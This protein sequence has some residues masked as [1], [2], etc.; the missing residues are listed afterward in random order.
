[1]NYGIRPS[2]N[3]SFCSAN[4]CFVVACI[5][6]VVPDL[7]T[8]ISLIVVK[9]TNRFNWYIVALVSNGFLIAVRI[10]AVISFCS[11]RFDLSYSE[12][13]HLGP[14]LG[15]ST[16]VISALGLFIALCILPVVFEVIIWQ[17]YKETRASTYDPEALNSTFQENKRDFTAFSSAILPNA[18]KIVFAELEVQLT[19]F[20]ETNNT[21]GEILE[22]KK[23]LPVEYYGEDVDDDGNN[24]DY[25]TTPFHPQ[26][27]PLFTAASPS[28]LPM[29]H[30]V[31]HDPPVR[32]GRNVAFVFGIVFGLFVAVVVPI[33]WMNYGIKPSENVSFCSATICF[34]VACIPFVVPD[35][36]TSISLIVVKLTNRF[37]WYIVALVSNGFLIAVR[38]FAVIS[39]CSIRFDQSYSKVQHLGPFLGWSALVISALGLF[40]AL[41]I[42]PVV[43]E[44]II[45]QACKET[46]ASTYDPE[47]RNSMRMQDCKS[48]CSLE[49]SN[50]MNAM[51]VLAL[52]KITHSEKSTQCDFLSNVEN[53]RLISSMAFYPY[54]LKPNRQN[55][56]VQCSPMVDNA[57]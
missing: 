32:P 17:A 53:Q 9:L 3:V 7:I 22:L 48:E 13:Q 5:P 15:W 16:L 51:D 54:R 34:A 40:I 39:F 47:A 42:L 8:S 46:R 19:E 55:K 29:S 6:F 43:F 36:I 30:A 56:C 49:S 26:N 23:G 31:S 20:R 33:L 35:L 25:T 1:M 41:C 37:N 45:W 12:V 18:F 4:I 24:Y 11:I 10:F 28:R 50:Y 2:E 21:S 27:F 38:I 52:P 14:F 44:V 57:E